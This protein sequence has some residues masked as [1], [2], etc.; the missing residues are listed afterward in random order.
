MT[1]TKV[2][3]GYDYILRMDNAEFKNLV[4]AV[5]SM[6]NLADERHPWTELRNQLQE[7][8]GPK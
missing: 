7:A 8:R 6:C 1:I 4:S 3:S 5:E 2:P